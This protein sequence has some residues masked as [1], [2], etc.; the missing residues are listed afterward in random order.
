MLRSWLKDL[1]LQEPCDEAIYDRLLECSYR[2]KDCAKLTI[3]PV[4]WGERHNLN[5][6]ASVTDISCESL[7]LG[8]V[9]NSL[10]QGLIMNIQSMMSNDFLAMC[11]VQK[12]IGTGSALVRNSTL[13]KSVQDAF[14]FQFVL[15][16]DSN[17]S[18]G[19]AFSIM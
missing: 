19:A 12:I 5:Q 18:T 10:C 7:S 1:G 3:S 15:C 11:G 17:A 13:Q 6:L 4:L 2:D 8:N 9:Y 16:K 14:D